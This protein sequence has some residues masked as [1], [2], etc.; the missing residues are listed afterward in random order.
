[1]RVFL[2]RKRQAT[3]ILTWA[4]VICSLYAL[5]WRSAPHLNKTKA[6]TAVLGGGEAVVCRDVFSL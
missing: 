6:G 4:V 5:L 2:I 3:A 1:M